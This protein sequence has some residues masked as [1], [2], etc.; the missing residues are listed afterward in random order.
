MKFSRD[1]V[2]GC[3]CPGNDCP[4]SATSN[5]DYPTVIVKTSS[6]P[7][8]GNG[9]FVGVH[10]VKDRHMGVYNGRIRFDDPNDDG[11]TRFFTFNAGTKSL[12]GSVQR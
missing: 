3:K 7:G 4:N 1:C 12:M 6:I 11:D 8:A 10:V 5:D 2:P 9:A